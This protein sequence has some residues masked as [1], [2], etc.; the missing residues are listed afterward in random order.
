VHQQ[1]QQLDEQQQEQ[2]QQFTGA[3]PQVSSVGMATSED[4]S[5]EATDEAGTSEPSSSSISDT[6]SSSFASNSSV[7]G[8]QRRGVWFNSKK[9]PQVCSLEAR[10]GPY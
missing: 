2:Q 5:N 8:P 1:Q 6:S 9:Q 3:L 7:W 10:D 4:E